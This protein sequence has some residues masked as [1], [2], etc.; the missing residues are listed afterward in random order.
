MGYSSAKNAATM[1]DAYTIFGTLHL[2]YIYLYKEKLTLLVLTSIIDVNNLVPKLLP[3][4][5]NRS[6]Y[7]R[8]YFF[9][10]DDGHSVS[11]PLAN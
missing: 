1:N 7:V 10:L 9:G 4:I 11:T 2:L 6:L 8:E 3:L 5:S